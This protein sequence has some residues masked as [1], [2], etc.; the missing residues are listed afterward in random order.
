MIKPLRLRKDYSS[1]NEALEIVSV[2]EEPKK[3][4]FA[5]FSSEENKNK[6]NEIKSF[7]IF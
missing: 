4:N 2:N 1:L 3:I 6:K 5:S 7:I